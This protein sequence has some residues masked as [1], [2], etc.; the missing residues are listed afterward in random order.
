MNS[1]I[2]PN[3]TYEWAT[4]VDERFWL[5]TVAGTVVSTISF[6]ENVFLFAMFV[7]SHAHRQS[8]SLYLLSLAFFDILLAFSYFFLM[9]LS[10]LIDVY[11]SMFLLRAWYAYNVPLNTL[12]HVGMTASSYL[13]VAASVERYC[14]TANPRRLEC[15]QRY[16]PV[17]V[18]ATILFGIT[19]MAS[20]P[21]EFDVYL[22]SINF[23]I[24]Y[25]EECAGLLTEYEIDLSV[26]VKENEAYS[27]WWRLIFRNIFSVLLPFATLAFMNIRIVV[28]VQKM[29]RVDRSTR[30]LSDAQQKIRVRD[31]TRTMLIV[32]FTYLL[33]KVLNVF[34]TIWE[35][36]DKE[37]LVTDYLEFYMIST[38]VISISTIIAGAFRLPIY[39]I[40]QP[41]L[42]KEFAAP[43]YRLLYCIPDLQLKT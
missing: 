29:K 34:I 24:R 37:T 14:V 4:L 1:T 41:D 15:F 39:V 18:T 38:D 31:A 8:H 17:I 12:S 5:V 11:G 30:R 26:L 13:I 9:S 25:V 6:V 21:F 3:C 36:I 43:L 28:A 40:C 22:C 2:S 33:S 10:V 20:F 16:R 35:Y 7:K 23:S 19:I 42:R 32:I 27:Y